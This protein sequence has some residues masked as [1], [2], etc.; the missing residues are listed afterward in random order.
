MSEI[1]TLVGRTSADKKS[2]ITGSVAKGEVDY[3]AYAGAGVEKAWD[4]SSLE[5]LRHL[6]QT[7]MDLERNVEAKTK[8][9]A[10]AVADY[11]GIKFKKLPEL[12]EKHGLP[13]FD[14]VDAHTGLTM[15]IKFIDK[16][17]VALPTFQQGNKF[18]KDLPKC[19][20]VYDWFREIGLGG[21]I[22]KQ[23]GI[24]VG[25]ETDAFV[26]EVAETVKSKYPNLDIAVTEE[27]HSSTLTSQVTKLKDSGKE[28]HELLK[29][30]AVKCADV[31]LK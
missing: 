26:Q 29:V 24:P 4:E 13:G 11:D 21:I 18:V 1:E 5:Y 8:E 15:A 22:K 9:L 7:Q 12:M 20:L 3:G 28:V 2:F 17:R 27:I 6:A 30:T 14:F 19:K 31:K 10:D 16:W 25:L 23:I